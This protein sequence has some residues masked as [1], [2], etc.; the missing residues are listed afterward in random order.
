M[1][2]RFAAIAAI[3]AVMAT[4]VQA[5][6]PAEVTAAFTTVATDFGILLGLGAILLVAVTG[7][8]LVLSNG[9]KMMNKAGK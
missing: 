8:Y 1:N 6:V 9:K 2:K 3:P 4:S 7:G 5:A